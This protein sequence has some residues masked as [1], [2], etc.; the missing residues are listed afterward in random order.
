VLC[1]VVVFKTDFIMKPKEKAEQLYKT[2]GSFCKTGLGRNA[3]FSG[4]K[5]VDIAMITVTEML[6]LRNGYFDCTNPMNDESYWQLV[7][8]YLIEKI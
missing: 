6:E 8:D 4:Q 3:S 5:A 1:E 2:A 7:R